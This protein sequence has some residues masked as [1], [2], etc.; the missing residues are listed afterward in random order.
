[1]ESRQEQIEQY[2]AG[3]LSGSALQS[4]EQAL[5]ENPELAAELALHRKTQAFLEDQETLEFRKNLQNIS[6]Q[7]NPRESARILVRLFLLTLIVLLTWLLYQK[8]RK[9]AVPSP[10]VPE[11]QAIENLEQES[12]IPPQDTFEQLERTTTPEVP[13]EVQETIPIA[14]KDPF[15]SQSDWEQVLQQADFSMVYEFELQ[16]TITSSEESGFFCQLEGALYTVNLPEGQA[17]EIQFF[18]NKN[19]PI[20]AIP[21]LSDT[22]NIQPIEED[23]VFAFAAK[24]EFLVGYSTQAL[25]QVGLYYYRI[26]LEDESTGLYAG[27]IILR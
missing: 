13:S 22:L 1:M 17:F 11:E 14:Q 6:T 27:K 3:T 2:L 4:F 18:D 12:S 15:E 8:T 23:Q 21:I 25:E 24:K 7:S 19:S 9:P 16:E 5:A 10:P 26:L 20:N